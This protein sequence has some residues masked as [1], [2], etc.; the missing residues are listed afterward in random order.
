VLV[1]TTQ[2]DMRPLARLSP[3]TVGAMAASG[4]LLQPAMRTSDLADARAPG[5][6]MMLSGFIHAMATT[7]TEHKERGLVMEDG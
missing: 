7:C 6:R 2:R 5:L 4:L 3:A 1:S